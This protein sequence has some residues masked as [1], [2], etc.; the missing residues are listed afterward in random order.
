VKRSSARERIWTFIVSMRDWLDYRSIASTIATVR[1]CALPRVSFSAPRREC[2]FDT[3]EWTQKQGAGRS[4]S[5]P[6]GTCSSTIHSRSC[7]FTTGLFSAPPRPFHRRPRPI[8]PRQPCA[9]VSNLIMAMT[10]AGVCAGQLRPA[11]NGRGSDESRRDETDRWPRCPG[12]RAAEAAA[13]PMQSCPCCDCRK[14]VFQETL[15][16]SR[17][18]GGLLFDWI[19]VERQQSVFYDVSAHITKSV[20]VTPSMAP[21][22]VAIST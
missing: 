4:R 19:A 10:I 9:I 5:P 22:I 1:L 11:L 21:S 14:P 13:M 2:H 18:R 8:G 3:F 15:G 17:D 6:G 12:V 16:P 20:P 7:D